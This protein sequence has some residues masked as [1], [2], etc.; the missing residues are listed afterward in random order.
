VLQEDRLLLVSDGILDAWGL[1]LAQEAYQKIAHIMALYPTGQEDL[2]VQELVKQVCAQTGVADDR[3]CIA[4][5]YT[6]PNPQTR[7][8]HSKKFQA[9]LCVL[10]DIRAWVEQVIAP[11]L[12][13]TEK[14]T[15]VNWMQNMILGLSETASN[16]IGHGCLNGQNNTQAIHLLVIIDSK[17]LWLEWHY[18]G[19][20]FKPPERASR[21]LPEPDLLAQSG[22]GLSI[23]DAVFETVHYFTSIPQG[24]SILTFKPWPSKT[25]KPIHP[26]GVTS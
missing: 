20:A 19:K 12:D 8:V 2:L 11:C 4:L 24:Q 22:Y 3:S 21:K 23:V 13:H 7:T 25:L 16:V 15:G 9:S 14:T 18:E 17:G 6:T 5:L 1:P 26:R 10:P